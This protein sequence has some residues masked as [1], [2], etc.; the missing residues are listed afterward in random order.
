MKK[1]MTINM[2]FLVFSCGSSKNMMNESLVKNPTSYI[3]SNSK[4]EVVKAMVE[5]LGGH[6]SS[7]SST[8]YD[9]LLHQYSS[10]GK[11]ELSPFYGNPSKVYFRK[12]GKA[13]FYR[14]ASVMSI[15][16]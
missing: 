13:Y 11:I 1:L 10:S 15:L 6:K 7:K 9:Y 2:I 5:T 12:N 4:Q 3:F 16:K 8:Y 14:P